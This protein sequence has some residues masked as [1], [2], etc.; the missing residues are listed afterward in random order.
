MP[1]MTIAARE[2][3]LEGAYQLG[4]AAVEH[5]TAAEPIEFY[6]DRAY[7]LSLM[8]DFTMTGPEGTDDAADYQTLSRLIQKVRKDCGAA[9]KEV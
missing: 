6:R 1:E 5:A 4:I 3:V 2:A 9:E 7:I 8:P